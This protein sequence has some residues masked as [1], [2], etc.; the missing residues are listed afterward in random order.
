MKRFTIPFL[1]LFL[2]LIT[3]QAAM[4]QQIYSDGPIWRVFIVRSK[5]AQLDN[6]LKNFKEVTVPCMEEEKK[7]G[8]ILDYKILLNT[9]KADPQDWDVL[10]A[11]QFKDQA[12]YEAF[13]PR[14]DAIET[15]HDGG[16]EGRKT[17]SA[18]RATMKETLRTVFVKEINLK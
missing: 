9:K 15:Q 1:A 4:A 12:A 7:L 16:P 2:M 10:I 18:L 17:L 11:Y 5:P 3:V 14:D 8:L 6:Y 13:V